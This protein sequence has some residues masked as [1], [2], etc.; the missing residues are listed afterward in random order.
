MITNSRPLLQMRSITKQYVLERAPAPWLKPKIVLACD[1]VDLD[2][3][4]AEVVALVGE[5]GSGKSTLGRIAL[6]LERPD[7]GEVIFE[8]TDLMKLK[9]SDLRRRRRDFQVVF[10]DPLSSLNPRWTLGDSVGY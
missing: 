1:D 5:S 3:L 8:G 4:P 6:L 10:Q 9:P 7:S 2:V